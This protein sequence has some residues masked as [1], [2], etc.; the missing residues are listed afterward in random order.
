MINKKGMSPVTIVGWYIVFMIVWI[1]WGAEQLS[2][3]GTKI[4][5]ENALI[6]IEAFLYSNLN[7]IVLIVSVIFL[8]AGVMV[9][10]R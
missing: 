9:F 1:F 3:Y 10:S 6:G 7:F 2:Y 5:T 8:L 4:V